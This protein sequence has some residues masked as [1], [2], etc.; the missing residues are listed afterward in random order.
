MASSAPDPVDCGRPYGVVRAQDAEASTFGQFVGH[1]VFTIDKD[2]AESEISGDGAANDAGVR[3]H[4]KDVIY[5]R[6]VRV[7]QI[8]REPSGGFTATSTSAF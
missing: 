5:G 3:F 1:T 6:D 8:S 4:E 7:W 2:G